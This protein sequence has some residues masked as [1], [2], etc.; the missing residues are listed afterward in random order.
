MGIKVLLVIV[1]VI[2]IL[3]F[4]VL[5][6]TFSRKLQSMESPKNT[7][8]LKV[9]T[10][11]EFNTLS[12]REIKAITRDLLRRERKRGKRQWRM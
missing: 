9:D 1:F 4:S 10:K 11:L 5:F 8:D 2:P 3:F 7:Y 12:K 6:C